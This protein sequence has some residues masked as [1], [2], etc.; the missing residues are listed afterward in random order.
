M[1]KTVFKLI[2]SII[3]SLGIIASIAIAAGAVDNADVY[4]TIEL[5]N[6]DNVSGSVLNETFTVMTPY[7]SVAL[8]KNN[9]SKI[10]IDFEHENRDVITLNTGG[11]M[12]G[13]IEEVAISF[14]LVS[15][16]I[17]SLEKKQCKNIIL[18]KKR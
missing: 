7:T 17:I 5:K 11:L 16:K 13:T 4:D 14:K 15:G 12:E 18:N 8:E 10:E 2:Y 9:I 6:G 3:L 1:L